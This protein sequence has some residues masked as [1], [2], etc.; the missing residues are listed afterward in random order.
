MFARACRRSV[1][2]DDKFLLVHAFQFDPSPAAA[3]GFVNGIAL[4]AEK[5]LQAMPFNFRQQC[6]CFSPKCSRKPNDVAR[7][8]DQLPALLSA[9]SAAH[10]SN[11][12]HSTAR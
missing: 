12:G 2:A 9:E 5:T 11:C 3:A 8:R 1:A 7:R 6:F 10:L 4:L